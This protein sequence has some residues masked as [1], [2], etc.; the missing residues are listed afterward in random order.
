MSAGRARAV[1]LGPCRRSGA[2]AP[3]RGARRGLASAEA[4]LRERL[5]AVQAA[6]QRASSAAS[7]RPVRLVAVSKT[8]PVELLREAYDAG[9]RCFGEN[10]VQ[11]LVDKAPLMPSDTQW[12]FVGRLQSNKVR[13]LVQGCP[14]LACLETVSSE[15]LARAVDKAWLA[16][17]AARRL[18]VMVQV[19]SSGE[20]QKNGVPP[21]EVSQLCVLISRELRGLELAGLM[22]I[23]APDYSGCRT[24]DFETLRTCR[25]QAAAA[26]GV[27]EAALELSMGMSSDYEN[28]ILEGS[29]SVRVG[30]Q[31]FGARDYASKP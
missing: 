15:K 14:S 18:P 29:T 24:E 9:Q 7:A 21:D 25:A 11:E 3:G 4:P 27:E 13:A 23:G 28:A 16:A 8:K 12:H 20:V 5:A 30:S 10:Y 19:N 26:L 2:P 1:L 17:G 22:T 31:I 6:V